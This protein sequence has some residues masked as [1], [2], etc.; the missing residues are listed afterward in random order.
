MKKLMAMFSFVLF[1]GAP[2][3]VHAKTAEGW[4]GLSAVVNLVEQQDEK[5]K[6]N[7]EDLPAAVKKTLE[8]AAYTGW[9]IQEA[10]HNK[11][12]DSYELNVK[13]GDEVKTLKFNKDGS[14]IE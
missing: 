6:I 8:G 10:Y 2:P 4:K 14:E 7:K 1:A 5:V 9:A 3:F 11:T 13:K 12:K